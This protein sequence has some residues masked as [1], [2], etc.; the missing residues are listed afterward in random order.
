MQW[1]AQ[2]PLTGRLDEIQRELEAASAGG[3]GGT[4]PAGARQQELRG[5]GLGKSQVTG[6]IV[7]SADL[8]MLLDE[9]ERGVR[10]ALDGRSVLLVP[11]LEPSWGILFGRVAAVITEIGGELS[12]ASILLREAGCIAVVNCAG[13]CAGL[14]DGDEVEVN[15]DM[16]I[17][18]RISGKPAE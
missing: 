12:H 7:K 17:V 14:N 3:R 13:A 16:G 9:I 18:S 1:L 15:G 4:A 10:P 8:A 11:A 6:T 2:V 5:I